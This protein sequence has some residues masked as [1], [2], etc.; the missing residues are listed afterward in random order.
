MIEYH[1]GKTGSGEVIFPEIST[2]ELECLD[3]W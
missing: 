1:L 2:E 3:L